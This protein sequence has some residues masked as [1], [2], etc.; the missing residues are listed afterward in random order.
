LRRLILF[1]GIPG[2][3]KTTVAS[4]LASALTRS[5]HIQTDGVRAMI[6]HPGYTGAESRFVYETAVSVGRLALRAGYDTI[7]DGTFPREGFRREAIAGLRRFFR[8]RLVVHVICDPPLALE[9]NAG[10]KDAIPE[11]SLLRIHRQ[12]QPPSDAL[13][14]DT[15]ML[16]P[17]RAVELILA[18]LEQE[19]LH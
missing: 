18:R 5:V 9:R 2:S 8:A 1:C 11:E 16:D 7:L 6:A 4:A 19:T 14:I 10:R 3:G 13:V 12:F 15:S 17:G